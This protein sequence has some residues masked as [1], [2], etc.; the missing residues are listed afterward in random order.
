[1]GSLNSFV[2]FID[3]SIVRVKYKMIIINVIVSMPSHEVLIEKCRVAQKNS[4]LWALRQRFAYIREAD[5]HPSE[6]NRNI[7]KSFILIITFHYFTLFIILSSP[8][9]F[10]KHLLI[11]RHRTWAV[12]QQLWSFAQSF[13]RWDSKINM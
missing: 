4:F 10:L 6:C 5:H 7:H 13:G 3:I 8:L 1:M 9:I 2:S 11:R 12:S